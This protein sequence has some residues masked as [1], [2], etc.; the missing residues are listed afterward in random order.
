MQSFI[1]LALM[2]PKIIRGSLKTPLDLQTIKKVGLNRIKDFL[3]NNVV[4]RFD[5]S[6]FEVLS[7]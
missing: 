1:W 6:S 4:H 3:S 5:K 2:V 7:A